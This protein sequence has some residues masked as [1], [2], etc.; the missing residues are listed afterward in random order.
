[1]T[2]KLVFFSLYPCYL[3]ICT[4]LKRFAK[5]SWTLMH[6]LDGPKGDSA[7][8]LTSPDVVAESVPLKSL[9]NKERM[10]QNFPWESDLL[11]YAW[12]RYLRT[13]VYR[14][15]FFF[16]ASDKKINISLFP[17]EQHT[18]VHT[19]TCMCAHTHAQHTL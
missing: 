8:C 9:R 2:A 15:C 13:H 7:L 5:A 18:W 10:P 12:E 4:H 11:K 16:L 1:M 3:D 19:S 6:F 17:Y 14:E